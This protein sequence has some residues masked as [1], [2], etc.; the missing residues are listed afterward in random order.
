MFVLFG[1]PGAGK[2][3]LGSALAKKLKL[4]FYDIDAL[5]EQTHRKPCHILWQMLGVKKYRKQENIIIRTLKPGIVSC[6][7]G[8]VLDPDN[9]TQLKGHGKFVYLSCPI[10][11]LISRYFEK[12]RAIAKTKEQLKALLEKRFPIYEKIPAIRIDS[13]QSLDNQIKNIL[14][15]Y[16]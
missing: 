12:P 5:L 14:T 4:P 2:S 10:D 6:G 11:I 3:T 16:I 8:T 7:G 15:M 13:S 1:P 9:V